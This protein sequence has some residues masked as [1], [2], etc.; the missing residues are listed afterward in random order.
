MKRWALPA[1]LV[2][3]VVFGHAPAAAQTPDGAAVFEKHCATC[4]DGAPDSRA[5]N[6]ATL[7]A[8]TMVWR[9]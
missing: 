5:P 7:Q 8:R 9:C 3:L 6:R 1:S 4:H 2:A